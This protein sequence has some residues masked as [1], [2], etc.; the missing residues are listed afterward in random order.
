MVLVHRTPKLKEKRALYIQ[1]YIAVIKLPTRRVVNGLCTNCYLTLGDAGTGILEIF[2]SS[3]KE[4][5]DEERDDFE[6]FDEVEEDLDLPISVFG[7]FSCF[8]GTSFSPVSSSTKSTL[9]LFSAVPS[10]AIEFLKK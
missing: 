1:T 6:D 9:F 2:S 3:S 5:G 7:D 8:A 4:A 10:S